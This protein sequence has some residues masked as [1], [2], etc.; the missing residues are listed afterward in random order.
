MLLVDP[1]FQSILVQVAKQRRIPVVYD[2]V[3]TGCWRLGTPTAGQLLHQEPDIAC[4]AKLLTGGVAPLAVTLATEA[5]FNAFKGP[6]KVEALLH[7]H[8]YTA[9]PL[10]CAAALASLVILQ[11]PAMNP[12]ICAP[13]IPGRCQKQGAAHSA[14]G[15][16]NT[17][18]QQQQCCQAACGD[19]VSLWDDTV[20]AKLSHH[21][22]IKGVM[23]IGSVFAIELRQGAQQAA[24]APAASTS[25]IT[26]SSGAGSSDRAIAADGDCSKGAG[27]G[28][29]G[30]SAAL[31]I[32]CALRQR[33]VAARPVGHVVYMM[34]P[35]TTTRHKCDWLLQQLMEVLESD[36]CWG[37]SGG[38]WVLI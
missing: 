35:P 6:S 21:P 37:S 28:S 16:N 18:A 9:Y 8:S 33:G 26:S 24:A 4:Y 13:A 10:G 27:A 36:A 19:L 7:G 32:V 2:E 20:P 15:G 5:V 23:V 31:D 14:G 29:Y 30:S 34:V 12:N 22:H 1:L 3:F 25:K 38:D 17:A 11:N